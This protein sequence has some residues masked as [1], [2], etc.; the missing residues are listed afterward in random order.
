LFGLSP[1]HCSLFGLLPACVRS[2]SSR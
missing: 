2:F 1:A